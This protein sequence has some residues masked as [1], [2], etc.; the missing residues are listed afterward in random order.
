MMH[1]NQSV[2][3]KW[4]AMSAVMAG[5]P[6]PEAVV[7]SISLVVSDKTYET[8]VGGKLDSGSCETDMTK[9]PYQMRLVGTDGPNAGKTMLAVFDFS[10]EGQ[11]RVAYDLNG[12]AYPRSF[13]S[14]SENG[15]F[16]AAYARQN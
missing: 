9:T 10:E 16:V 1:Q 4:K 5:E 15:F 6:F 8:N 3:G 13:D 12:L 14:T 11:M 2:V 7:S